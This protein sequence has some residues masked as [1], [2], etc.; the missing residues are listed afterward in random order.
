MCQ[1]IVRAKD[2]GSPQLSS[3]DSATLTVAVQRNKNCPQFEGKSYEKTIDQTQG[4]DSRVLEMKAS[5]AD[6]QVSGQQYHSPT[7]IGLV[8]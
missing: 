3:A 8:L 4:V 7:Q 1:I 2:Q 6:P 5:D